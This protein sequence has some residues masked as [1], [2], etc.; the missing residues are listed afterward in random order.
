MRTSV[1]FLQKAVPSRASRFYFIAEGTDR[2]Y[3]I[4]FFEEQ[5]QRCWDSRS[6]R[7]TLNIPRA[8]PGTTWLLF[9]LSPA[10][11]SAEIKTDSIPTPQTKQERNME[12]DDPRDFATIS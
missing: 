1:P 11:P 10:V 8:F 6:L 4:E 2:A 9:E 12:R 3:R 5:W 7:N